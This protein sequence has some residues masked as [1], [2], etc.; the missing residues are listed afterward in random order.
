MAYKFIK[1]K[2]PKNE[3]DNTDAMIRIE[4][5]EVTL[6]EVIVA[7]EDFLRACGYQV[8]NNSLGIVDEE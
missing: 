3:F 8:E 5:N 2:D 6:T 1:T 4:N 7:F